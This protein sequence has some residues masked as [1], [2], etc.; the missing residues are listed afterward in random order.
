LNAVGLKS[1]P[2]SPERNAA[3]LSVRQ[4]S[5]DRIGVI[6]ERRMALLKALRAEL[7]IELG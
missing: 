2:G 1:T 6:R 4:V 3:G 5:V 7:R